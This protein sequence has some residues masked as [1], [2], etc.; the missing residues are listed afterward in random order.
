MLT[1]PRA[2]SLTLFSSYPCVLP[3]WL[4]PLSW[5]EGQSTPP[6]QASPLISGT[7]IF[8]CPL[9]LCIQISNTHFKLNTSKTEFLI[10]YSTLLLP[11]ASHLV[12]GNN[13]CTVSW[14]QN[15][16]LIANFPLT[17]TPHLHKWASS[18]ISTFSARPKSKLS[19]L[20]PLPPT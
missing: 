3:A 5:L 17:H 1:C 10:S 20:P 6:G 7:S 9:T 2:W 13:I 18:A 11:Q 16:G 14:T 4:P 15:L 8:I 19:L 12:R